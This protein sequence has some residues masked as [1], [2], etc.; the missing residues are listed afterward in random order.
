MR[1]TR[2]DVA[3]YAHLGARGR[4]LDVEPS[5]GAFGGLFPDTPGYG[6]VDVGASVRSVWSDLELFGRVH[7]LF[8]HDYEETLGFPALG[9]SAIV[10]VRVATRR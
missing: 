1:F 8:D 5:F 9:R 10:G 3:A 6:V 4:I 7:N 2:R